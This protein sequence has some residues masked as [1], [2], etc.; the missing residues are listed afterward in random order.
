MQ[1]ANI[2]NFHKLIINSIL[3]PPPPPRGL[4]LTYTHTS[5]F[6]MCTHVSFQDAIYSILAML[7]FIDPKSKLLQKIKGTFTENRKLLFLYF[8]SFN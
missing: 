6:S 1:F 7:I 5:F 2:T 3:I 4:S 8:L